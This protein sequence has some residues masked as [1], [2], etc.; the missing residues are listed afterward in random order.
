[1]EAV[2]DLHVV[3]ASERGIETLAPFH[4]AINAEYPQREARVEGQF[5][6]IAGEQIGARASH[7]QIG[8]IYRRE[9]G[10]YAVQVRVDGMTVSR[11]AP[12]TCWSDLRAEASR[13]WN[14]YREVVGADALSRIGLRYINQFHLPHGDWRNE[15]AL[16]PL[17]PDGVFGEISQLFMRVEAPQPDLDANAVITQ[18]RIPDNAPET[19]AFILDIDL[20]LSDNLPDP[21]QGLWECLDRL[22]NRKNEL[23]RA[24]FVHPPEEMFGNAARTA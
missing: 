22:R 8:Y 14:V 12:Y 6:F 17:T 7:R 11:F 15:L 21:D 2:I 24:S 5:E 10:D 1:M 20:M 4:E 16:R 23:F 9:A 19:A 18:T 13:W 3:G